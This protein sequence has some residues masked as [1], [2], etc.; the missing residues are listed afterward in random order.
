MTTYYLL[1]LALTIHIA[2]LTIAGG[3]S[4]ANFLIFQRFRKVY[5][6][7]TQRA[8][9][10]LEGNAKLPRIANIGIVISIVSG[11]AMMILT[12]G[13]FMNQVWFEIKLALLVITIVNIIWRSLLKR[14]LNKAIKQNKARV[15]IETNF[16]GL[17][18]MIHIS[19]FIQILLFLSIFFLA[20]FR[21]N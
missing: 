16:L 19:A 21:F 17:S 12:N 10:T 7:D 20:S 15:E 11:I 13:A 9:I 3:L 1:K 6:D 14:K 8:L 5:F 2:G 4:L 18:N